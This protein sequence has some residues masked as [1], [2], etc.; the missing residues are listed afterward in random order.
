MH[1]LGKF[2]DIFLAE[3]AGQPG[4]IRRAAAAAAEQDGRLGRLRQELGRRGRVV[5][6]GMGSSY[7]ACYP[8]ATMLASAGVMATMVD[9]AELLH[10]RLDAARRPHAARLREPVR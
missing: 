5:L 1:S 10:F 6:T 9:A 4:A 2:P 3:I 8:A 7:D